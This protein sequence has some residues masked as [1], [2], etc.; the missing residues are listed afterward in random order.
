FPIGW[1]HFA[2]GTHRLRLLTCLSLLSCK[3]HGL[4]N[5]HGPP[6]RQQG[7]ETDLNRVNRLDRPHDGVRKKYAV[8]GPLGRFAVTPR[9][10]STTLA[11]CHGRSISI[12]EVIMLSMDIR[13]KS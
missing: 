4:Q 11:R 3:D 12:N 6:H 5:F 7:E 13:K 10:L 8:V 9:S 2:L 1:T